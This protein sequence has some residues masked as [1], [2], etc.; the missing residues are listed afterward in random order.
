MGKKMKLVLGL[1]S[2]SLSI[3]IAVITY[4]MICWS[5]Y[6]MPLRYYSLVVAGVSFAPSLA[7]TGV[8]FLLLGTDKRV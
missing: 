7:I 2:L 6:P 5:A 4:R 8:V 3:L 1:G